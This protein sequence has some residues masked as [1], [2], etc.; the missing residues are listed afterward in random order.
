M[1]GPYQKWND[2]KR[3]L[4]RELWFTK[5]DVELQKAFPDH[6]LS[7]IISQAYY[8]GLKRHKMLYAP[9]PRI[10]KT[11]EMLFK[12]AITRADKLLD[13]MTP[14]SKFDIDFKREDYPYG[15][16]VSFMSDFHLGSIYVDYKKL[17]DDLELIKKTPY[18][19]GAMLG[20]VLDNFQPNG[21]H[22]GGQHDAIYGLPAQ[23]KM[24][25]Y[26]FKEYGK[27]FIVMLEGCHDDWS[28]VSDG[29]DA[30]ETYAQ[31]INGGYL[32]YGGRVNLCVGDIDYTMEI[33]HKYGRYS[34]SFNMTNKAKRLFQEVGGCDIVVI[35]HNHTPDF[36]ILNMAGRRL[37]A[38][39]NGAYKASDRFSQKS[40]YQPQEPASISVFFD[41]SKKEV[42]PFWDMRQ[43]ITYMRGLIDK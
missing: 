41:P 1:R 18:V 23:K 40:S 27:D 20:D 38:I 5:S 28:W 11:G 24:A 36:E 43:A 17:F 34:S 12:E 26:I 3:D 7:S 29:W 37:V 9:E 14:R 15:L 19:Y 25:S 33:R 4:L 6:S 32:G 10:E 21:K 13:A 35:A 30:G 8:L 42:I 16:I 39:C 2:E 31:D 22:A